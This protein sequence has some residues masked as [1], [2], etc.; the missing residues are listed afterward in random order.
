MARLRA[1][2]L[3][4]PNPAVLTWPR[5][6]ASAGLTLSYVGR[7]TIPWNYG[8]V[9]VAIPLGSAASNRHIIMVICERTTSLTNVQLGGTSMTI[10][11]QTSDLRRVYIARLKLDSGEQATLSYSTGSQAEDAFVYTYTI[12]GP[13]TLSKVSSVVVDNGNGSADLSVSSVSGGCAIAGLHFGSDW[14]TTPVWSGLTQDGFIVRNTSRAAAS[15][16]TTASSLNAGVTFNNYDGD[17]SAI[18]TYQGS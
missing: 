16:L 1:G 11:A 6:V 15:A 5:P 10:D 3:V 13:A 18:V 2:V 14:G 17:S 7:T 8:T 9:S 4:S 12:V